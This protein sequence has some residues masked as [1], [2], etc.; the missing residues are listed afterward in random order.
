MSIR[1][2]KSALKRK[3]I[4]FRIFD[5]KGVGFELSGDV[6]YEQAKAVII[7]RQLASI[8]LIQRRLRIGYN[9]A[10][11]LMRKLEKNRI[12]SPPGF[13]GLRKVDRRYVRN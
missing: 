12:V 3:L 1:K 8:S 6:L 10:S 9:A 13:N 7:E 2:R 4:I 5:R 11:V